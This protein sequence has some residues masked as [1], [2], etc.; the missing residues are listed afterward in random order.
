MP[1]YYEYYGEWNGH[2]AAVSDK[3]VPSTL[4][5]RYS[6]IDYVLFT[7]HRWHEQLSHGPRLDEMVAAFHQA[8]EWNYIVQENALRALLRPEYD[9]APYLEWYRLDLIPIAE[10]LLLLSFELT[11]RAGTGHEDPGA[12]KRIR[13]TKL[14]QAW[15]RIEGVFPIKVVE[16]AYEG[17]D[18]WIELLDGLYTMG[19]GSESSRKAL[20]FFLKFLPERI[21]GRM[22]GQPLGR[23]K[24]ELFFAPDADAALEKLIDDNYAGPEELQRKLTLAKISILGP[25]RP[26]EV[27]P[28][29]EVSILYDFLFSMSMPGFIVDTNGEVKNENE[30]ENENRVVWSFDQNDVHPLGYRMFVR[31]LELDRETQQALTGGQALDNRQAALDFYEIVREDKQLRKELEELRHGGRLPI[32]TLFAIG[33]H[34]RARKSANMWLWYCQAAADGHERTLYYLASWYAFE[35]IFSRIGLESPETI[36]PD[37]RAAFVWYAIAAANGYAWAIDDRDLLAE[38]L[39]PQEHEQA[40]DMLK[41]WTPDR[42]PWPGSPS[43]LGVSLPR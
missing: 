24:P 26:M 1:D 40:A 29:A 20:E 23:V 3:L 14:R 16:D 35:T 37:D 31:S 2:R 18:F 15:S 32:E 6:R 7:E 28:R 36:T 38:K 5:R 4:S 13:E 9:P 22:D 43:E 27:F 41:S 12:L 10:E 19:V 34:F 33:E 25:Y 8:V 21:V 30:N 17:S 11:V 42:C 39:T